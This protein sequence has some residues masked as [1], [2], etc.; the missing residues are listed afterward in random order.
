MHVCACVYTS[1]SRL[2]VCIHSLVSLCRMLSYLYERATKLNVM[3][4]P[5]AV[6]LNGPKPITMTYSQ[7]F[8]QSKRIS[9]KFPK[10][11]IISSILDNCIENLIV[12]LAITENNSAIAPLNYNLSEPELIFYLKKSPGGLVCKPG[13]NLLA[14]K[15][16]QK[17]GICIYY[18]AENEVTRV[19][20]TN[21]ALN[22]NPLSIGDS[23]LI[24]YTSGT[25]GV[26]KCVGLSISNLAASMDNIIKT[27][28]LGPSDSTLAIMPLFHIHGLMASLFATLGSGG[29]VVF[30]GRFSASNFFKQISTC[31]WFTAVPTMHWILL[32]YAAKNGIDCPPKSLRFVRSCSSA[33]DPGLL[34]RLESFYKVS[35]IE[36]YAMTEAAHQMTSNP[37]VG[38]K[39]GTVGIPHG[40][41]SVEI[42]DPEN[43]VP[44]GRHFRGEVCVKGPNVIRDY[45]PPA[46]GADGPEGYFRTGDEGYID[47]DGYLILTGRM[48]ELINRGGEKIS[49]IEID[50]A[51]LSHPNILEA[52]SFGI[53]DTVYGEVVAAVVVPKSPSFSI[54]DLHEFLESKL[55]KFKIP[56]KIWITKNI[57]KTDT[58]KIQRKKV[59]Q[60]FVGRL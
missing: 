40:T 60:L 11:T 22:P 34:A 51:I 32:D 38:R 4:R 17:L 25:T 55:S 47:N 27:Y 10:N 13:V 54:R 50:S 45:I 57:P 52:V 26:P 12:F 1:F 46:G 3:N 37:L 29:V 43:S 6:S 24:L 42:F 35:V 59:A 58:G 33:L 15:C 41:V 56:T 49:P 53:P 21:V 36:A 8:E 28:K 20:A 48:K 7:V 2:F 39:P 44:M 23:R 31:T 18:I 5:A 9:T 14:E 30:P 19:G 16:A